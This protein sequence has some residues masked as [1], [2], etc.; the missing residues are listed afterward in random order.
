[1]KLTAREREIVEA[2]QKQPLISQ[3][4]LAQHFGI[5]RS[6]VAVHISNLMKKGVILGKGYVFNK[7]VS[8][9]VLGQV[10][11]EIKVVGEKDQSQID[12]GHAGFARDVC[13]A[14]SGYGISS[15][16]I[17]MV[18]NE[19][20]GTQLLNEIQAFDADT[21]TVYRHP[22]KRTCKKIFAQNELIY[23]EGYTQDDYYQAI[24]S[25]EWVA[26]NCDWL[27][28]ESP[29][30]EYV[31]KRIASRPDRN[32]CICGTWHICNRK[33]PAL[34]VANLL[35]LGVDDFQDYEHYVNIGLDLLQSGTQNCIITDGKDNMVLVNSSGVGDYP[36]PP[37]QSFDSRLD[38]HFFMTGLVYGLS[39]G[40][41]IRQ[42]MRIASGTAQTVREKNQTV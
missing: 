13:Q 16:V 34:N 41:P 19:D 40:Y 17:T 22:S 3:D 1:M 24:N 9:V 2:L 42:A 6:S 39:S 35:V 12:L 28:V 18:G 25:R 27:I 29:F 21:S 38:L 31:S 36:L 30:L 4:E 10:Y 20:L 32:T 15:K 5:S 7:K 26:S 14:L 33:P 8:I 11:L 23:Q 37:N